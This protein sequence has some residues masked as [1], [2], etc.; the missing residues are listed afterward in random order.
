QHVELVTARRE[1]SEVGREPE[2]SEESGDGWTQL[3]WGRAPKLQSPEPAR[4][5]GYG[6]QR[7]KRSRA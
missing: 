6:A 4:R 2:L 1:R 7:T 3:R 5:A